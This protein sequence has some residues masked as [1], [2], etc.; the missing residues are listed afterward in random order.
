VAKWVYNRPLDCCDETELRVAKFLARLADDWTVCW[1]FFYDTDREGDF[2]ILGP[3]GGLLVLEV[4]GGQIRKLGSTGCWDGEA[5]DH[6]V[7]QLCAEWSAVLDQMKAVARGRHYPFVAKAL[8]LPDVVL[9]A[10]DTAYKTI[11]RRL[12]LDAND[13]GSFQAAWQR[14]FQGHGQK[15]G[16]ESREVFLQAYGQ[17]VTPKSIQHFITET[18]RLLLRH[19]VQ[20]FELLDMLRDNRHLL[21]QGGPGTGKTWLA[22]EQAYRLAEADKGSEVLLLCYNRALARTLGELVSKRKT[23]RGRITVQSWETLA[24]ELFGWAKIRWKEPEDPGER[25]GYFTETVPATML[26]IVRDKKFLPRFEALVVDEGQDHDTAFTVSDVAGDGAGWW[27]IYWKL[28][29][30]G[31]KAPMAVF[32]DPGQRPLFRDPAAFDAERL[33]KHL[34]ES[35]HV[36]LCNAL[37]YT[38]PVFCFLKE[39]QSKATA[40]LVNE[41]RHRGRLLEGPGVELYQ[42]PEGKLASKVGEIVTR[43]IGDGFCRADE[44]LILSPHGEKP[45]TG[46]AGREM[47]GAWKLADH[48]QKQPGQISLLSVNKAKGLDSLAVVLIDVKPFASLREEQD[49]MDY[50]TGASR[51][52]Q[53]LAVVHSD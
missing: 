2:I 9:P 48:E 34:S 24:R 47:V 11:D 51:A 41:M 42:A 38:G 44:I 37:R 3:Y 30:E 26:K 49:Q 12:I 10:G 15:V 20:E 14:L 21:V 8:G 6:P 18:D 27:D 45:R 33:R 31:T 29:K 52:R 23:R 17:D 25:Q 32:Y 5:R 40:P 16:A 7:S 19:A 39:L 46:L 28:L 22:L 35:V 53:L 43:W 50:F 13:L 36:H 4:K 1:G